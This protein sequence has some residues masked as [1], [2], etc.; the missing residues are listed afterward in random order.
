MPSS[1]QHCPPKV[2]AAANRA[3]T[4]CST[5]WQA[6]QQ[7]AAPSRPGTRGV[8]HHGY[9]AAKERAAAELDRQQTQGR[10]DA[11]CTSAAAPHGYE[12]ADAAEPPHAA[13]QSATHASVPGEE[14]A[15]YGSP[16]AHDSWDA[17]WAWWAPPP[18]PPPP[19]PL[20]AWLFSQQGL[21][22][23]Q[24]PA[25]PQPASPPTAATAAGSRSESH[26]TPALALAGDGSEVQAAAQAQATKLGDEA[27]AELLTAWFRAGFLSG[28]HAARAAVP[29]TAMS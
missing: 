8:R 18:P 6:G 2:C 26:G 22:G 16:G 3:L 19:P 23:H 14:H 29:S 7:S 17:A 15:M 21:T 13:Q 27:L 10:R 20:P 1:R 25:V 28:Q 12:S 11:A 5:L 4:C 24:P 9:V